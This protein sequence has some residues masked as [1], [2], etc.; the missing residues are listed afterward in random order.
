MKG[1]KKNKFLLRIVQIFAVAAIMFGITSISANASCRWA[2]CD[3]KT[4]NGDNAGSCASPY[5]CWGV[6]G[7]GCDGHQWDK[8]EGSWSGWTVTKN[9]TCTEAGEKVRSRS[10]YWHCSLCKKDSDYGTEYDRQYFGPLGHAGFGPWRDEGGVHAHYCTRCGGNRQS[11]PHNWGAWHYEIN[12]YHYSDCEDRYA[13][14][15]RQDAVYSFTVYFN[16][17]GGELIGSSS[18]TMAGGSSKHTLGTSARR[19][20]YSFMGWG[21]SPSWGC[22]RYSITEQK[23]A[24]QWAQICGKS[25]QYHDDSGTL[26]AQWERKI[27]YTFYYWNGTQ[28]TQA[29]SSVTWHNG[30]DT[31]NRTMTIPNV[32][33]GDKDRLGQTWTFDGFDLDPS[34]KYTEED[35]N[36]FTD[37]ICDID[38]TTSELSIP[39]GDLNVN[40]DTNYYTKYHTTVTMTYVDYGTDKQITRTSSIFPREAHIYVVRLSA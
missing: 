6:H 31:N 20:G 8:V 10:T 12:G 17:N 39:I 24:Y 23:Q 38:D 27:T 1:E 28:G 19:T 22:T 3:C 5:R 2:S 21:N 36:K 16:P 4:K 7:S 40:Y 26:Y 18:K 13:C 34:L 14:N 32:A 15:A 29:S 25:I 33:R 37:V 35:L 30:E 11:E 9:A